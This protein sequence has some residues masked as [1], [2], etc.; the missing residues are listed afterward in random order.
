[1]PPREADGDGVSGPH[2]VGDGG[3]AGPSS[4]PFWSLRLLLQITGSSGRDVT[5]L[6][7]AGPS[8][9]WAA[10][11]CPGS[12][13]ISDRADTAQLSP[14]LPRDA[15][16]VGALSQTPGM[17]LL[18]SFYFPRLAADIQHP[19]DKG[20][21]PRRAQRRLCSFRTRASDYTFGSWDTWSLR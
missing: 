9:S 16:P 20:L 3:E 12:C 21:R 5:G 4:C 8:R 14:L 11:H 19:Q 17:L 10:G 6:Q 1:M 7:D 13:P 15:S 18:S 2:W